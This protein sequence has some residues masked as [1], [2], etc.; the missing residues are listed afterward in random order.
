MASSQAAL[1]ALPLADRTF[2]KK[3]SSSSSSSNFVLRARAAAKEIHFNR[4][5]SVTKKLQVFS[6]FFQ[7]L[8]I[9]FRF[10][11]GNNGGEGRCRYGG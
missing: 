1:S 5:G 8:F 4:D 9:E 11:M 10:L 7:S 3:P 2:R 6:F